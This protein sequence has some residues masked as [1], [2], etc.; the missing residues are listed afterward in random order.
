MLPLTGEILRR[1]WDRVCH[2]IMAG[3][4]LDR[5]VSML[6]WI[7]WAGMRLKVNAKIAVVTWFLF[8]LPILTLL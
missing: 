3:S 8:D 5:T 4:R 1:S 6:A 7:K 2:V